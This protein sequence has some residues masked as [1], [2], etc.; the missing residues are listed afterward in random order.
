MRLPPSSCHAVHLPPMKVCVIN[1]R[2]P[3]C[4]CVTFTFRNFFKVF[5]NGLAFFFEIYRYFYLG[6]YFPWFPSWILLYPFAYL[7][8]L[9]LS[10]IDQ[11][12]SLKSSPVHFSCLGIHFHVNFLPV[13]FS[14]RFR[15]C[16]VNFLWWLKFSFV[17]RLVLV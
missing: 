2:L 10:V 3:Y 1:G 5:R 14:G 11:C 13:L 4:Y 16:E 12:K 17:G 6:L 7:E 9:Y 15:H 8:P